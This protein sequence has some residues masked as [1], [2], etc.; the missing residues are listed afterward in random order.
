MWKWD[1]TAWSLC[2][3]LGQERPPQS[4]AHS[5]WSSPSHL[6]VTAGPNAQLWRFDGRSW[7]LAGGLSKLNPPQA[8]MDALEYYD[9]LLF[10]GTNPNCQVR[11]YSEPTGQWTLEKDL[12]AEHDQIYV[13]GM[14]V[15]DGALYVGTMGGGRHGGQVWELSR[16]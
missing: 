1:G 16:S 2:E 12:G 9:S 3:D 13:G 8:E 15:H 4:L 10:A 11:S 7:E 14:V 6:Y 5:L